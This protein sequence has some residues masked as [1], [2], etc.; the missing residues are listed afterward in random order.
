MLVFPTFLSFFIT[1][2]LK[3]IFKV[4]RPCVGLEFCPSSYSFP[5][6]HA[7]I[8]GVLFSWLFFSTSE[9]FKLFLF[10]PILIA[11]SRVF[12]NVHT[13]ID[14]IIGFLI[15]GL[16]FFICNKILKKSFEAKVSV[17]ERFLTRKII[18]F[19][20]LFLL[21]VFFLQKNLYRLLTFFGLMFLIFSE[22]MR[23]IGIKIPL[24]HKLTYYCAKNYEKKFIAIEAILY[25]L[26]LFLL[27]FFDERAFF[28]GFITL[29]IGD[30]ISSMVGTIFGSIFLK[31][32]KVVSL[33]GF[34]SFVIFVVPFFSLFFTPEKSFQL[35]FL[36]AILES[37]LKKEENVVL[38]LTLAYVSTFF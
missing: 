37:V 13:L 11:L 14:I 23:K 27:S 33:E 6:T 2:F 20:G 15:G 3:E 24:I 35:A 5:S 18:H 12:L 16:S 34:L 32:R 36:G 7:S 30:F 26:A 10:F 17:N 19:S 22:I 31:T 25:F 38:P 4:P 29:I 21:I 28:V 9:K 8:A 1:S